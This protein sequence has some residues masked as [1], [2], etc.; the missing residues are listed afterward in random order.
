MKVGDLIKVRYINNNPYDSSYDDFG[1][2]FVGV[3]TQTPNCHEFG[4]YQMWCI[5]TGTTHALM[6]ERDVIEELSEGR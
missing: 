6:P 1:D 4:I 5:N 2:D 3:V